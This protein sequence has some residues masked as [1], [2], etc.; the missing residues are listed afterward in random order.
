MK[1][2]HLIICSAFFLVI[3]S[4]WLTYLSFISKAPDLISAY[5]SN[6]LG[7]KTALE[8]VT[9]AP[10]K[11]TLENLEIGNIP[12]GTLNK[13][14]SAKEIAIEFPLIKTY[15]ARTKIIHKVIVD[16]VYLGLEFNSPTSTKGNW[17]TILSNFQKSTNASNN[18][19]SRN[20]K[21]KEAP[22]QIVIIKE[23]VVNNISVDVLYLNSNSKIKRLPKINQIVIKNISSNQGL[24]MDQFL[25]SLL[26][27]M[28]KEVFIKEN[29]K[30]MIESLVNDP[31]QLQNML[32]PFKDLF[33]K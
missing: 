3:L 24:P 22:E 9:V 15:F 5:I 1:K 30:N 28:L 26:G 32:Q 11:I 10:G 33:S 7:V 12:T 4:I 2:K 19:S 31:T 8:E 25:N 20:I 6:R 18:S 21:K 14:F 27:Q 29:L 17:T 13:A 23:L 16:D